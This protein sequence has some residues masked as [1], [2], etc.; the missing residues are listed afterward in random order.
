[1]NGFAPDRDA[2]QTLFESRD[3]R[4][5]SFYRKDL[6]SLFD[7]NGG[8]REAGATAE[9]ED[10][11][12]GRE[13]CGPGTNLVYSNAGGRTVVAAAAREKVLRD[14]FVSAGSIHSQMVTR[15]SNAGGASRVLQ[16]LDDA[17]GPGVLPSAL[18]T[19]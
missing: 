17:P 13:C 14:G 9:V 3:E 4:W 15:L 5:C 7:Q 16:R 11:A 2:G 19:A 18:V 6:K 1:L 10:A 8:D 12:A